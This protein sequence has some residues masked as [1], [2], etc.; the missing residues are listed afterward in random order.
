MPDPI[1]VRFTLSERTA[2]LQEYG[3]C[4]VATGRYHGAVT[5]YLDD[6][7]KRV[8]FAWGGG[9][10][11]SASSLAE[12]KRIVCEKAGLIEVDHE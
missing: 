9:A 2:G 8:F 11:V 7:G 3:A 12:A 1:H 4:A 5:S 6:A 10:T